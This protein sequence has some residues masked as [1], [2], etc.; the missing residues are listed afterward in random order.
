MAIEDAGVGVVLR[1]R[2]ATGFVRLSAAFESQGRYADAVRAC[3]LGMRCGDSNSSNTDLG[4]RMARARVAGQLP[5]V[6]W[7]P[8]ERR[9][10]C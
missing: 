10:R 5:P 9:E 3:Y 2:I 7:K 1:P 6:D 8:V 4:R